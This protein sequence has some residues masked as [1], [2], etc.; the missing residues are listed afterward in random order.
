M[1][2]HLVFTQEIRC[3]HSVHT[4]FTQCSHA[5]QL[6]RL[7]QSFPREGNG[8]RSGLD[9]ADLRSEK[10][11]LRRGGKINVKKHQKELFQWSRKCGPVQN[12]CSYTVHTLFTHCSHKV[13]EHLLETGVHTF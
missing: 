10:V 13:C 7:A 11:N 2:T 3:S 6:E 12:R 9:P 8:L 1:F 5:R 4:V